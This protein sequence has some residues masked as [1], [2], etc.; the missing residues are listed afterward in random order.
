M[1]PA[2][3]TLQDSASR[4]RGKPSRCAEP[5]GFVSPRSHGQLAVWR[6]GWRQP[7]TGPT[8]VC[9][10]ACAHPS[11]APVPV[12][13]G[14]PGWHMVGVQRTR[15]VSAGWQRGAQA[16]VGSRSPCCVVT[17]CVRH[18]SSA[19]EKVTKLSCHRQRLSVPPGPENLPPGLLKRVLGRPWVMGTRRPSSG[20]ISVGKAPQSW[21][22]GSHP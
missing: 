6:R 9:A 3:V 16:R 17:R 8:Y 18:T 11:R 5:V 12:C 10:L 13:R 21:E 7:R 20:A 22:G 4:A 2:C 15:P 14:L 19:G 1:R